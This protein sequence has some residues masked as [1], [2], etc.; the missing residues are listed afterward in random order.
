MQYKAFR[1]GT[2]VVFWETRNIPY[3]DLECYTKCLN[4][5]VVEFILGG[6]Q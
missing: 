4:F 5:E 6:Y 3:V 2:P 1:Q